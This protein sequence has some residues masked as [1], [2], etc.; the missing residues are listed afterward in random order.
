M[1]FIIT[2]FGAQVCIITFGAQV[3]IITIFGA[4]VCIITIFGA[5]VF[6]IVI[7]EAQVCISVLQQKFCAKF[8]SRNRPTAYL[9]THR[10]EEHRSTSKSFMYA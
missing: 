10:T 2:I 4:Q 3:C 8:L 6:I 9:K 1:V 7:F 5:Q